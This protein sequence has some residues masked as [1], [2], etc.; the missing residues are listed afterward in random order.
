MNEKTKN[1]ELNDVE[2]YILSAIRNL[3]FGSVAVT[4]HDAAVVQV[5]K[6][7]KR[8]FEKQPAQ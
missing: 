5:E 1:V 4:I 8:R 6:S 7:E 2:Q 3:K